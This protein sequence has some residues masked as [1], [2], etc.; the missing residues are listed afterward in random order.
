MGITR[1]SLDTVS[2]S[3]CRCTSS[4]GET[5]FLFME[6]SSKKLKNKRQA[7]CQKETENTGRK[8]PQGCKSNPSGPPQPPI[9]S[10]VRVLPNI[11]LSMLDKWVVLFNS[12]YAYSDYSVVCNSNDLRLHLGGRAQE[13]TRVSHLSDLL[14]RLGNNPRWIFGT[15]E[16]MDSFTWLGTL[17]TMIKSK[18]IPEAR[19]YLLPITPP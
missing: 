12:N 14:E 5:T 13:S 15:E 1:P 19:S 18:I 16:L 10:A 6:G 8:H 3:R 17:Q 7:G 4:W 11:S 9:Q 2:T